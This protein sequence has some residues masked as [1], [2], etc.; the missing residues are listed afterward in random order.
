MIGVDLGGTK[1]L[2]GILDR[3]GTVYET[4]ERPTV[5]TSQAALLDEL[6]DVVRSLPLDGSAVG[7]GIPSR[8]DLDRPRA[9]RGEHPDPGRHFAKEMEQ[10]LHLPVGMENDASCAA[11]AEFKLGAGRGTTD[12]MLTLGTGVGGGIVRRAARARWTELGHMVIV[13]DGKPCQG[14]CSG[15]GHVEA[16]CSGTRGRRARAAGARPGRDARD[17]V[18]QGH[19][20]LER[21]RASPRRRDRLARQHLRLERVVIGGGFGVAAFDL[22]MPAARP[23]VLTRGARARGAEARD[24]ARQ[25]GTDAGLIGAGLI[26]FEGLGNEA[27]A[28]RG[29]RDPDRESRGHHAARARGAAHG[30][31]RPRRGHAAHAWPARAPR[32]LAQLLSYHEH[33]EAS[34]VA[35]LLPRL[36]AGERIALVSDAGM[37]VVSD[38]GARLVRAALEPARGDGA[39][40]PSAVETA[41][42]ASG[43]GGG[44]YAFV[45]FLPR[46]GGARGG[47][48]R[49]VGV[50]GASSRSSRRSGSPRRSVRSPRSTRRARWPCAAS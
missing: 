44:P 41:L 12:L 50:G 11:F 45:G 39:A 22:L 46:E 38:P 42:V 47:L 32:H 5:T 3:D 23:A 33:N 40:G 17:L 9:R 18:A 4:V 29:L 6:A 15:R 25:L 16:Y 36:A 43:L 10:R 8:I 7:F 30:R 24:R 35:E 34:R 13:E 19:P 2:A 37:P 1:I 26:A 48:A 20:A 31:R 28:A 27:R 21:D 14:A 49:D